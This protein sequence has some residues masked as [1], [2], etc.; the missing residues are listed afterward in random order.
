[1]KI[2]ITGGAGFLGQRLA[3][4]LLERGALALDGG[5]PQPIGRI[6]LLD[7]AEA[8]ACADPRMRSLVGDIADPA[9]LRQAIDADTR[10]IFHLAAIVSG[11]AE[12]DFDLGMRINLDASR[13]LLETCR[14]L[15]T[16][17]NDLTLTDIDLAGD[18]PSD[19]PSNFSRKEFEAAVEKS[20]EYIAAGDIFQ[21][22][23]SQR[24]QRETTAKPLDIYRALR[25]VNPSPFMFLLHSPGLHLVGSSPEIAGRGAFS[26]RFDRP[27]TYAYACA[28]HPFMRGVVI[29]R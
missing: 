8:G 2:L 24:L 3:R 27:G 23:L 7:V 28:P 13:A 5:A 19:C 15:G 4:K 11:Q 16:S 29:V 17:T 10:V 9:V 12:T 20:R 14:Q 18:P 22:V 25:V 21:V 26:R 1:M 6:D